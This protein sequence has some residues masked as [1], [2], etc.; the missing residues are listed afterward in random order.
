MSKRSYWWPLLFAIAIAATPMLVSAKANKPDTPTVAP[1]LK[2]T[3]WLKGDPVTLSEGMGKNIYVVEFWA[4]WCPPCRMSIPH[5]SKLQEKYAEKG[6]V[7]IGITDE[8]ADT[9]KPFIEKLGDKLKYHIALDEKLETQEAYDKVFSFDTIPTA[10]VVG[11]DGKI[12]WV[13]H[14][15]SGLEE[16]LETLTSAPAKKAEKQPHA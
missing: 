3:E 10:F 2:V 9:V 1:E 15:M 14:P 8:K 11:K 5:L 6:V 4:T 13:G 12:A 16:T 7:I